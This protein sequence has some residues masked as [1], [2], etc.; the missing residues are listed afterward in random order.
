MKAVCALNSTGN[1]W[2]SVMTFSTQQVPT[3]QRAKFSE[4]D[5]ENTAFLVYPNPTA[6]NLTLELESAA[7]GKTVQIMNVSGSVVSS[8]NIGSLKQ[9]L[10]VSNLAN[11]VYFIRYE[12]HALKFI[13]NR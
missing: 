10:D 9:E 1:N 3:L 5:D 8:F 13:L 2:T 11:G 12:Q 6:G 7:I 4:L